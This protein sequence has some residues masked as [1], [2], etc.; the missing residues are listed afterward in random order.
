MG[1]RI[2]RTSV[3]LPRDLMKELDRFV[4][5]TKSNR[6]K[7]VQ[8][9]IRNFLSVPYSDE[10]IVTGSL[11]IVYNHREHRLETEITDIQ[12]CFMDLI[13]SNL[14]IHLDEERCMLTIFVRGSFKT[15][16]S[17]ARRLAGIRGVLMVKES[18]IR[19]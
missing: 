15:F 7:V 12:H 14:H 19:L 5:S 16:K 4:D 11:T 18:L 1:G 9:A 17:L 3:S 10:D 2:V 8:Q 6:S 13:V